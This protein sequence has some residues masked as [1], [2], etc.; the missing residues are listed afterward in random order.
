MRDCVCCPVV[1]GRIL[2]GPVT[3]RVVP[4]APG[5]KVIHR[6]QNSEIKFLTTLAIKVS[7]MSLTHAVKPNHT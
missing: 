3:T 2:V 7:I 4:S 5:S 6:F 1:F